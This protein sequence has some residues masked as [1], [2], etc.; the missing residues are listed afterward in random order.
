MPSPNTLKKSRP[1]LVAAVIAL[2]GS[3]VVSQPAAAGWKLCVKQQC[4]SAMA[5]TPTYHN[6]FCRKS[7]V[8]KNVLVECPDGKE[9]VGTLTSTSDGG[10]F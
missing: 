8:C 7:Q 4:N 9:H 10:N 5:C 6:R 2:V 1:Y 3:V